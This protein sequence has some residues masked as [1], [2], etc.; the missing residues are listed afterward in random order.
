MGRERPY[1]LNPNP[2]SS[3]EFGGGPLEADHAVHDED[4]E[5]ALDHYV[6]QLDDA[7]HHVAASTCEPE[8]LV[9]V[10]RKLSCS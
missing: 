4:E 1:T 2:G 3:Q 6:R 7:L 10:C 8:Q 9:L 5:G